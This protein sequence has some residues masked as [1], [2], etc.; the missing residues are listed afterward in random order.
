MNELN[1]E[2]SPYLLQHA[3][4]PVHWK[5]WSPQSIDLAKK[6]G[7]PIFI[8]IGYSTCHWCHVMEHESFESQQ[9]ADYLNSNF[10]CIKIDREE[11][12]D[13]DSIYMSSVQ[14]M[15]G[16][17]GWPLNVFLDS[18]LK[19]FYGGTYFRA[20]VFLNL[21]QK[22]HEA[23]NDDHHGL[24]SQGDH[25]LDHLNQMQNEAKLEG[26]PSLPLEEFLGRFSSNYDSVN[27]GKL[28]APKFPLSYDLIL[29]S[30]LNQTNAKQMLRQT[31][32]KMARSGTYDQLE[33]GLHRYST[34]DKWKVPHFEKMLYDQSA[35]IEACLADY[36]SNQNKESLFIAK[37]TVDY[38]LDRLQTPHGGFYSAEDAD[39]EGV[40][41]KFYR[42]DTKELQ[43][44]LGP[45]FEGFTQELDWPEGG[46][47][48]GHFVLHLNGSTPL[49]EWHQK[50]LHSVQKLQA[51]RSKRHRPITDT[52]VLTS[53]NGLFLSALCRYIQ[54][55]NDRRPKL[56]KALEQSIQFAQK[57][58]INS[59]SGELYRRWADGEPKYRGTLAD[60]TFMISGLID[61]FCV[62][63]SLELV[64]TIENLLKKQEELFTDENKTG[65]YFSTPHGEPHL[66][67]REVETY[68]NVEPS[69]NSVALKNLLRWYSATGSE[70]L[71]DRA[72]LMLNHLPES[73]LKRPHGFPYLIDAAINYQKTMSVYFLISKSDQLSDQVAQKLLLK[74]TDS[75]LV[76]QIKANDD[77]LKKIDWLQGKLNNNYDEP[78]LLFHCKDQSC[79]APITDSKLI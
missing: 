79:E 73:F 18:K 54:V 6:S 10:V 24:T 74:N 40:E 42:W 48:E 14:M 59:N 28:G 27:G 43:T 50:H 22:I 70:W 21:L 76:I 30:K 67:I 38:V 64:N 36:R 53:W 61:S 20:P 2:K 26:I 15:T 47:F 71:I 45:D 33:G 57:N 3:N 1:L 7:K 49:D 69:A 72:K 25:L 41:G 51:H 17:G 4:N 31:I 60:Y 66:I 23:W 13:V 29:L 46:H 68:D 35:F 12:P 19:P 34:D 8:S 44:L 11:H 56:I 16:R 39:S 65:L 78:F 77:L 58:L 52:K 63:P 37:K 5:A 55:S 62:R 75:K 9:I 32:S